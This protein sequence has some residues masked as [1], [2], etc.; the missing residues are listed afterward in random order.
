MG[1]ERRKQ[2][3]K[4]IAEILGVTSNTVHKWM[5]NDDWEGKIEREHFFSSGCSTR[6]SKC[7]R[8]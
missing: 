6:Q 7:K 3:V 1:R 2:E 8:E 4:D 5:A